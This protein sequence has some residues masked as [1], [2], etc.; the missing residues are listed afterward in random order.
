MLLVTAMNMFNL[1]ARKWR[2]TSSNGVYQ[3]DVRTNDRK[4]V[5]L[6]SL[7]SQQLLLSVEL[8]SVFIS[9]QNTERWRATFLWTY[10]E[11]LVGLSQLRRQEYCQR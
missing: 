4:H 5:F 6:K 10:I 2:L 1:Q 11:H 3:R 7:C 9:A 8:Y